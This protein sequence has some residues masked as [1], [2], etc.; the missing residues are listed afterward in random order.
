[1]ILS[2]W[3]RLL[4][5]LGFVGLLYFLYPTN[6]EMVL[7]HLQSDDPIQGKRFME[8]ALIKDPED[9]DLL[10]FSGELHWAHDQVD[11]AI[12]DLAKAV[13]IKPNNLRAL[14]LQAT[15][16]E[17]AMRLDDA[18]AAWERVEIR[19]PGR[20]GVAMKIASIAKYLDRSD[21]AGFWSA[22]WLAQE[23]TIPKRLAGNPLMKPWINGLASLA[24]DRL[25]AAEGTRE[26]VVSTLQDDL[27]YFMSANLFKILN[28]NEDLPPP[29]SETLYMEY[30]KSGFEGEALALAL[31][32]DGNGLA[33]TERFKLLTVLD[34]AG[35]SDRV[36]PVML[37][38]AKK[39][40]DQ[41]NALL[42][43]LELGE[44]QGDLDTKTLVLERLASVNP[45]QERYK[46]ELIGLYVESGNY[47][48]IAELMDRLA[49]F[50][51]EGVRFVR[52]VMAAAFVSNDEPF[53]Q[54]VSNEAEKVNNPAPDIL[55]AR[56]RL[57]IA[58]HD[59][60]KVSE[61]YKVLYEFSPAEAPELLK[62]LLSEN[63]DFNPEAMAEALTVALSLSPQDVTLLRLAA[64]N[65]MARGRP[66]QAVG[67]FRRT[68]VLTHNYEEFAQLVAAARESSNPKGMAEDALDLGLKYVGET[69]Q[70]LDLATDVYL[71]IDKPVLAYQTARRAAEL[72]PD[73]AHVSRM[74]ELAQSSGRSEDARE[75]VKLARALLPNDPALARQAVELAM[76]NSDL[77]QAEQE[78]IRLLKLEPGNTWGMRQ[79]ADIYSWTN[80]YSQA[81]GMLARLAAAGHASTADL[82][83][84]A[85]LKESAGE[86]LAALEM[87]RDILKQDPNNRE[88]AAQA[89]NYALWNNR[90]K[91]AA[92]LSE[93]LAGKPGGE[94]Y[95]L[96][97]GTAWLAAGEATRA[98]PWLEKARAS[99]QGGVEAL[100]LLAQA[101]QSLNRQRSTQEILF[102]LER[103][104]SLTP[105]DNIAL[106]QAHAA[107][108]QWPQVLGRLDQVAKLG[109]LDLE[110]QLLFCQALDNT[111]RKNEATPLLESLAQRCASSPADLIRVGEIA[112][113]GG[114]LDLARDIFRQAVKDQPQNP[115]ALR[116]LATVLS[117]K[118]KRHDAAR[119]MDSHNKINPQDADSRI[120]SGELET[121]LGN[122]AKAHANYM[123]AL[124]LLRQPSRA[125]N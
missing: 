86:G 93:K 6:T 121:A 61:I 116:G 78:A 75:A 31:A 47:D 113:Q 42:A 50:T 12:S 73:P 68:L 53:M 118:G 45:R 109:K 65:A 83:Q 106:A 89:I 87:L 4:F 66:D 20:P 36:P 29:N 88:V 98:L 62:S 97:A 99:G 102:E 15:Y 21:L 104:A 9:F 48:R 2:P 81:A 18:L 85:A 63:R 67:L 105:E 3:K 96:Q 37:E 79:L 16:L 1:M 125:V 110:G 92:E 24:R 39:A 14:I 74:I 23:R 35:L 111:S 49:W 114:R 76:G 46:T 112:Y 43:F 51:G 38:M 17:W 60:N 103:R 41:E 82:L 54:K 108:R 28:S 8:Q 26:N 33:L 70:T 91:I 13:S 90:P 120:Q 55:S 57:A 72:S 95:Q 44:Q 34:L 58:L 10:V 32:L 30:V 77:V 25:A 40:P 27:L 69:P 80:R 52:Q 56:V 59:L 22:K 94:K 101:Y 19:D 119:L 71:E 115:Q 117:D 122:E 124:K 107:L 11:A 7:L 123:K 84:L 5:F 100:R 64:R